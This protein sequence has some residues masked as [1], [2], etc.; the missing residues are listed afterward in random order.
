MD[1]D[2]VDVRKHTF[3]AT[4]EVG[5]KSRKLYRMASDVVRKNVPFD[6]MAFEAGDRWVG[7]G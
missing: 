4:D 2:S 6:L 5:S 3:C 7:G 1:R